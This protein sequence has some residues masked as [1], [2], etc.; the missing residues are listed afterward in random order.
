MSSIAS[1][2][3]DFLS[4]AAIPRGL[5]AVA[6]TGESF[7][8]AENER[9][10][11]RA[12]VFAGF[13]H[14]MQAPGDVRPVSVGGRPVLLVRGAHGVAAFHNICRHRC[15]QL[16]DR[17]GNAGRLIRCPYHS[18]AYTLDGKLAR[19]PFF[20]GNSHRPPP[21]FDPAAH[22][23]VGVR[24]ETWHDWI[25]VNLDG[26]AP[27]FADFIAPVAARL[28]HLDLTRL[29]PVAAID[30]GVINANWKFL[31]ENFIEPYHVQFV[32]S[33]TTEQPLTDHA[34]FID[35][36]CLGC[37][38]TLSGESTAAD[39]RSR[40]TDCGG[41]SRGGGGGGRGG[42]GGSRGGGDG[43]AGGGGGDSSAGGDGG[44]SSAGGGGDKN[45]LAVDS[46]FITL[47]PNFVLG[48]Y[49]PDQLGVHLNAPLGPGQTGQRRVIYLLRD[50][51]PAADEV[52]ALE[53]LWREV[54]AEDH[55]I[56]ERLQAG[57][58][59]PIAEDGGRLSPVWEVGV[60]R[61]QE[62][63]YGAVAG[64]A[65]ADAAPQVAAAKPFRRSV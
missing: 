41:G 45:T 16:V 65:G 47:F 5:P 20:G 24:C 14:E 56:C 49:A 30:F 62:L 39:T 34:P 40:L 2:F 1:S 42:G 60:R 64:D 19:A 59:S 36:H 22:G 17:P 31:M 32:H 4:P 50:E 33:T 26:N 61:F 13:A 3:T 54:H 28:A 38:V 55:A 46:S 23:L 53:K 63:V 57:R 25:F 51:M 18:W 29:K 52:A 7:Y 58:R 48:A 27:P 44:D 12:W 35:R 15:L 11:P 6:Y 21:G 43:S 37:S 9:L 8:A 10:F